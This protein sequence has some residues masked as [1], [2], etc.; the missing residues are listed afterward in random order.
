MKGRREDFLLN[1]IKFLIPVLTG[2]YLY[3][4]NTA[5]KGVYSTYYFIAPLVLSLNFKKIKK[6]KLRTSLIGPGL[7]IF[8]VSLTQPLY[9]YGE[10]QKLLTNHLKTKKLTFL[11]TANYTVPRSGPREYLFIKNSDYYYPL[12]LDGELRYFRVCP[13][14]GRF[15]ELDQKFW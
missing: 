10:G 12:K 13:L 11:E 4:V 1:F 6:N 14:S 5:Y 7:I 8:I 9:S 15:N 3:R 2:F